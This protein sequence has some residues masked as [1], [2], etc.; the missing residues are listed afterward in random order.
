[1]TSRCSECGASGDTP[2]Q[3]IFAA[4]KF[5]F[6]GQTCLQAKL[7][8]VARVEQQK[9]SQR[10]GR[11]GELSPSYGMGSRQSHEYTSYD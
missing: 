1:V 6:C 4:G 8:R 7:N 3:R 11:S 2:V 9:A 5:V 10:E